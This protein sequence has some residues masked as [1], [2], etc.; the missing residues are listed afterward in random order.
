MTDIRTE[1]DLRH[2]VDRVWRALTDQQLLEKWLGATD[3][4]PEDGAPFELRPIGLPALDG[5]VNGAVVEVDEPRRLVLRWR[6]SGVRVLVAFELTDTEDGCRLTLRQ[7]GTDGHWTAEQDEQRQH[8]LD[9]LLAGPLPAVLDWLAFRELDFTSETP[10]T[11]AAADPT[12]DGA[13]PGG[14]WADGAPAD[15]GPE[16]HRRRL[17]V[18]LIAAAIVLG[19]TMVVIAVIRPLGP[20]TTA[21]PRVSATPS[22]VAGSGPAGPAAGAVPSAAG[23]PAVTATGSAPVSP[24]VTPTAATPP[25][26]PTAGGPPAGN[27]PLPGRPNLD[28]RYARASNELLGYTGE[29]VLTNSGTAEATGWS[30]TVVLHGGATVTGSPGAD[31]DQKGRTVTFT[32]AAVPAGGSARFTFQ[33]NAALSERQPESCR[34]GDRACAGV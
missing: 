25:A 9:Q 4:V 18:G 12:V 31:H 17:A 7:S 27:A 1:V 6:E 32:G 3:L 16:R 30:V 29:I 11:D 5:A 20:T 13:T 23:A 21:A 28:A 34:V 22:G 24:S 33:V 14:T 26:S 2:P 15:G 10:T 19:G 8:D